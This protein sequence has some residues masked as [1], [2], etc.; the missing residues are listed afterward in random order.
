MR[1]NLLIRALSQRIAEVDGNKNTSTLYTHGK[2]E[3]GVRGV[4]VMTNKGLPEH[5]HC[6][7]HRGSRL[8]AT[9][10]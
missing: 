5:A 6:G 4:L 9:A 1:E 10:L 2:S 8:S 3:D 7:G